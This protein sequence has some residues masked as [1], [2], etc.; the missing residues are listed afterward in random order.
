MWQ[1]PLPTTT[2]LNQPP[3]EKDR[4]K[5]KFW[6]D[7]KLILEPTFGHCSGSVS[8]I[9]AAA[10]SKKKAASN[11][12]SMSTGILRF[13]PWRVMVLYRMLSLTYTQNFAKQNSV[14]LAVFFHTC[15][16]CDIA[17]TT[18][19]WCN[20]L[21][22]SRVAKNLLPEYGAPFSR[23]PL[24]FPSSFF[25]PSPTMLLFSP[26][27]PATESGAAPKAPQWVWMK[28]GRQMQLGDV[29]GWRRE[30]CQHFT[31]TIL[32]RCYA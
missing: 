27:N 11:F 23:T 3:Q 20:S 22:R 14:V 12:L 26:C 25:F 2:T 8:Q 13:V 15:N 31:V 1:T 18:N 28:R 4:W 7:A 32:L 29:V 9:L 6:D 30:F 19:S 10:T 24:H 21:G 5:K 16:V 17:I